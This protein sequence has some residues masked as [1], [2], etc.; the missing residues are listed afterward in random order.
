MLIFNY[1]L[2][3]FQLNNSKLS[4][5]LTLNLVKHCYSVLLPIC[6]WMGVSD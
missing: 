4:A 3:G 5:I 6:G 2:A 1:F